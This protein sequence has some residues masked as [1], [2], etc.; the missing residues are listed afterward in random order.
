MISAFYSFQV[1]EQTAIPGTLCSVQCGRFNSLFSV[2]VFLLNMNFNS[3]EASNVQNKAFGK[4]VDTYF[5][6]HSTVHV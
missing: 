5:T 1:F 6:F 2:G 4:Y 3:R